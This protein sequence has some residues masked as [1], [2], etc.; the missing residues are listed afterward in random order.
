MATKTAKYLICNPR[1][2]FM[3]GCYFP[4]YYSGEDANGKPTFTN[5]VYDEYEDGAVV[6]K[7]RKS[8]STV[9]K[10]IDNPLC[11]IVKVEV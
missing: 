7:T 10:A 11:Y 5:P 8:A 2:R 4:A 1:A 9:L 6:F 3:F